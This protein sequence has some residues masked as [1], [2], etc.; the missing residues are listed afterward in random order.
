MSD[1]AS[2]VWGDLI[3]QDAAI[4]QLEA[5][6]SNDRVA[7]TWMFTGPPGS[8][9][10]QIAHDFAKRLL[11]LDRTAN[12]ADNVDVRIVQT[13]ETSIKIDE[14]REV[15]EYS[16][17]FPMNE[18]YRIIIVHDADRMNE[19]SQNLILKSIEEPA[20]S[21]IWLLL[22]PSSADL[23]PTIR[24]RARLIHLNTP[25]DSSVA[26]LLEKDGIDHNLALVCA[27]LAG[28]HIGVAR[29]LAT[30]QAI[31]NDRLKV[32]DYAL[33]IS[34][35]SDAVFTSE[36]II[37]SAKPAYERD[38]DAKFEHL[39]AE[40]L[41]V[42]GV[43]L[44]GGK[45]PAKIPPSVRAQLKKL[46]D[47]KKNEQKRGL[48][49]Y[50][51]IRLQQMLIIYRDIALLQT[52]ADQN[53]IINFPVINKLQT[54]ANS[55]TLVDTTLKIRSIKDARKKILDTN[56]VPALVLTSLFSSLLIPRRALIK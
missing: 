37:N 41:Q 27:K 29:K 49:D 43:E 39:Q 13:S 4:S 33:S 26:I 1:W 11:N 47:D 24:S 8:G 7:N 22:A 48:R 9:R 46:E 30:N 23:L 17:M 21:T 2:D 32:A 28:G 18:K 38:I 52:G 40:V 3:D 50:I 31:F 25:K 45:V 16:R 10:T 5:A 36:D 53:L 15:V 19:A 35:I 12:L 42:N 14:M 56:C 54:Y 55:Q 51:D 34:N 44:V 6:I 20:E